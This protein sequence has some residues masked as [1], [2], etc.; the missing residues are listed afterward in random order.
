MNKL[1]FLSFIKQ[2]MLKTLEIYS[3]PEQYFVSFSKSGDN[4]LMW[5]HYANNHQD[6]CL[7][8]RPVDNKIRQNPKNLVKGFRESTA[9][10]FL[11]QMIFNIS[12][13]FELKPVEYISEPTAQKKKSLPVS[14]MQFTNSSTATTKFLSC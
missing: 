3:S 2:Q 14:R 6:Y 10:V 9:N 11:P 7:I 8:F 1:I 12:K 13:E 5:S 4:F